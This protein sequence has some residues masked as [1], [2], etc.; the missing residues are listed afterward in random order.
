MAGLNYYLLSA[1]PSLGELGAA[2]P[3]SYREFLITIKGNRRAHYFSE[4]LAI[5]N[6]LLL[7]SDAATGRPAA[8]QPLVLASNDLGKLD[9]F[10][11][12]FPWRQEDPVTS[13]LHEEYYRAA[14]E[15][16]SRRG[17][18]FISDWVRYEVGLLNSLGS[19]RAQ[20][21]AVEFTPRLTE[22]QLDEDYSPVVDAWRSAEHP[23]LAAAIVEAARWSWIAQNDDWFL[24]TDDELIAYAAKL[25]SL[26][27]RQ[28]SGNEERVPAG[29][30]GKEALAG[31]LAAGR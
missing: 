2:P 13:C 5:Q 12:F 10:R 25:L 16:A 14:H 3:L 1:L 21:Q 26:L 6:D 11:R 19:V 17:S 15:A 24:F 31:T 23:S 22:L 20:R 8:E 27:R 9:F 28:Q 7:W 18:R 30:T 29:A 4:V